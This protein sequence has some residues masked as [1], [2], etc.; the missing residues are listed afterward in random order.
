M[1]TATIHRY[2]EELLEE[3]E[4]KDKMV[5]IAGSRQCGK[6]TIAKNWLNKHTCQEHYYN[7]DTQTVKKLFRQDPLFFES[8]VRTKNKKSKLVFDEIH[9][10]VK[11]KNYLKG[12]YDEFREHVDFLVTG[13][14][15]L[16]FFQ[17]SGDSLVGRYHLLHMFP[18][19]LPEVL[20]KIKSFKFAFDF[21]TKL[22]LDQLA[23]KAFCDRSSKDAVESLLKFSGFPEPFLKATQRS[24]NLWSR[25]YTSRILR[26]DLRDLTR[27]M[28]VIRVEEAMELLVPT[29]SS[30]L[31][32][33]GLTEDLKCSYQS[34]KTTIN[35]LEKLF[36]IICIRPW[37]KSIKYSIS[38]E[39]KLYFLDWSR[40]PNEGGARFENFMAIQLYAYV[41]ILKDSGVANAEL[42]YLR[43]KQKSEVDF[44]I[45]INKK[46]YL[47]IEIK[48]SDENPSKSILSFGRELNCT[49]LIQAVQ[50]SNVLKKRDGVWIVSADRLLLYLWHLLC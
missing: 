22:N 23:D 3:T 35:A 20:N 24:Y 13:S 14:A 41:Q 4:I 17:K 27:I 38:K 36:V 37:F 40:C 44:L 26:E 46:P 19:I 28:D 42:F 8:E 43:N 39:R 16:D 33:N 34:V 45:T 48:V 2:I 21:N 49:L 11:W 9:K 18:L 25:E 47:M 31:S 6:T 15:R 12:C 29:V 5:F 7:W 1:T 10:M 50:T 30:T 32:L